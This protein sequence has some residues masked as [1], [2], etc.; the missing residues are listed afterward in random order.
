MGSHPCLSEK[1]AARTNSNIPYPDLLKKVE[2][3]KTD[4]VI[5]TIED[6]PLLDYRG[7]NLNRE[8]LFELCYKEL[9]KLIELNIS[10]NNL[11]DISPLKGLKAPKLAKLDVSENQIENIPGNISPS[12]EYDF[13]Q[14]KELNL[15][16]NILSNVYELKAIKAP[17]LETMNISYNKY[18]DNILTLNIDIFKFTFDFPELKTLDN[19]YDYTKINVPTPK[20]I[21]EINNEIIEDQIND[22]FVTN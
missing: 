4:K 1:N 21:N 10:D 13:P 19:E 12:K 8:K 17:K 22:L 15:S 3:I 11:I 9:S 7:L 16:K 14:L 5:I 2:T 18:N 20:S 6:K